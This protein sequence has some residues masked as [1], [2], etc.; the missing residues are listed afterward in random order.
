MTRLTVVLG[1]RRY[2]VV[3]PWGQLPEGLLLSGVSHV[4]VDSADR[5]YIYQRSDP[6]IVILDRDGHYVGARGQGLLADAHGMYIDGA[7]RL[8]V[9]DRDR[10]QLHVLDG[11]GVVALTLGDPEHPHLQ[12]PFNHPADVAVARNGDFYVADGYGNS[13]VH[14]FSPD[15]TLLSSWGNPGRGPGEFTTP[16]GV[17]EDARG[18]ILVADRENDR[19]QVFAQSGEFIAQWPTKVIG[20][21][22]FW[23][24][25]NDNVYVPEHNGGIFSVLTL[26]GEL[27]ARWGGSERTRKCHSVAGDSEGNVYFVQPVAGEGSV[28]R[29]IVKYVRK[30]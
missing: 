27:L 20:P 2:D 13:R 23:V 24:D 19:V 11:S 9:I 22:T 28:G 1:E 29:R 7:D 14:R 3:R 26:D 6:P 4:A 5:L 21:A 16:H 8:F 30:V 15:G 10:H 25:S 18:R 12:A 17:W